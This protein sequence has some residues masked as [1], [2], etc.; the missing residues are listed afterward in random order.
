MP[1]AFKLNRWGSADA[2]A[3]TSKGAV[4]MTFKPGMS[5]NEKG[6][7]QNTGQRQKLFNSLVEPHKEALF[8]TAIKLAIGGNESMLR[9]F[10]ERMLPAKPTDDAIALAIPEIEAN[11]TSTLSVWGEIVLQAVSHG[12]MTPDQG[13]SVMAVIDAQRKNIETS[14]LAL[15]LTEIER[16]LKQ[17]KKEK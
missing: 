4:K 11:N 1:E 17:R 14:E 2:Y 6:R 5:G 12:E 10:L 8:D 15:R 13:N 7:P 9:L 3:I 16:A